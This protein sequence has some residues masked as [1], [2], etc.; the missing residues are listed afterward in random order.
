MTV[1]DHQMTVDDHQMIVDDHQHN[2]QQV[3]D[4][5]HQQ[6]GAQGIHQQTSFQQVGAQGHESRGS[7]E[8]RE[9]DEEPEVKSRPTRTSKILARE[10]IRLQSLSS[11][12]LFDCTRLH[13]C[14]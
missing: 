4:N 7:E 3:G 5:I 14:D 11:I 1:D 9:Q 13:L 12:L 2:T 8:E 10:R 6:V